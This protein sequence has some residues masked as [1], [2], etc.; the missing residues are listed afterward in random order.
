MLAV[1]KIAILLF[2][3]MGGIVGIGVGPRSLP[4]H[5]LITPMTGKTL[6]GSK[7]FV[8][9]AFFMAITACYFVQ[10]VF[11]PQRQYAPEGPRIPLMAFRAA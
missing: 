6:P 9:G 3:I 10:H 7:G 5:F 4:C 8:R 2:P 1:A 11:V